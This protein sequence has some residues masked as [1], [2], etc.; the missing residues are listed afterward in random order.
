VSRLQLGQDWRGLLHR[1]LDIAVTH[2]LDEQ[3]GRAYTNLYGMLCR[4]RRYA[5]AEP[6]YRDAVAYCDEHDV[7]T[8]GT[9]LRGERANSLARMGRWDEAVALCR[10]VLTRVEEASPINR[11]YVLC[12]LA[13]V[14]ARR[15]EDGVWEAHDEAVASADG[16]GEPQWIIKSRIGRAEA[17]WLEGKL[18]DARAEAEFADDVVAAADGWLRGWVAVWLRRTGSDRPPRGVLAEPFQLE[19]DGDRAAAAHAWLDLNCPYDAALALLGSGDEATLRRAVA[20]LDELGATAAVRIA[21][22]RMRDQGVRSIPVGPRTP[23]SVRSWSR[24]A[25]T[26]EAAPMPLYMDIHSIDG[27]VFVDD[28]VKA[29]MADLQTQAK[30]DVSYLRY[31]VDE[32]R[33]KIFC[34]AEAPTAEAAGGRTAG[35]C[36]V[37]GLPQRA[38]GVVDPVAD[39]RRLAGRAPAGALGCDYRTSQSQTPPTRR[40]GPTRASTVSRSAAVASPGGARTIAVRQYARS[41][42]AWARSA[43]VTG[44]ARCVAV[45][46]SSSASVGR[47]ADPTT[48]W[49]PSAPP[50]GPRK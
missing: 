4:M 19:I 21:R 1:A 35:P 14:H 45:A 25:T 46:C 31:W 48:A 43:S 6:V 33:G 15:D 29:H 50:S 12:G 47:G 17:Y 23:R 9:C 13:T 11:I 39:G 20:M 8:F 2:R 40:P 42:R 24:L 22:Q 28:V 7:D 41:T 34:L 16:C 44:G 3:A 10:H 36:V 18:E 27:G 5:E 37:M 38:P 30:Y 49:L 32:A 26:E